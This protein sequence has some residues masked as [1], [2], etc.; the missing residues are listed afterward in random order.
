MAFGFD[1][2]L[3]WELLSA[4]EREKSELTSDQCIIR[5]QNETHYF[6]RACLE[7]PVIGADR[8]FGWGVWVSLGERSFA[9]MTDNWH[10]PQRRELGPYFGWLCA[11]I[12][13]YPDTAFLKTMVH[14]REV[15]LR[16][17][18]ELEPTDHPLSRHQR[19]GIPLQEMQ[20]LAVKLLREHGQS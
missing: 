10:N 8:P 13:G 7:I 2:P 18:V 4:A 14:N 15:G 11:K 9:E 17:I 12:P 16:P 5:A 1:R 6:V 3:Q 20:N 19:A